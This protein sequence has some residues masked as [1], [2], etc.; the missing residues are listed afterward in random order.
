MI[1][2]DIVKLFKNVKSTGTNQFTALCPCHNDTRNSLSIGVS[3]DGNCTLIHC[4]AGCDTADILREVGL[5]MKDLY[6]SNKPDDVQILKETEYLYHTENGE[7][8][9]KKIRKDYSDGTKTFGFQ[10]PDGN[11]GLNGKS[12]E[13]YNLPSIL[14]SDMVFFVE[15]EKCAD[16]INQSGYTATTLDTGANSRW[17][18]RYTNYLQNKN[19]IAI[20]DND[21]PGFK[22]AKKILD[23]L[24]SARVKILPDISEKEDIFDWIKAGHTMEDVLNLPDFDLISFMSNCSEKSEKG[25]K[26]MGGDLKETQAEK[27]VRLVEGTTDIELFHDHLNRFYAVIPLNGH[28]EIW[29]MDTDVFKLWLQKIYRDNEHKI[30][31]KENLTQA[32]NILCSKAL[33]ENEK[34]ISLNTRIARDGTEHAIWYDL[35]NSDWQTVKITENGWT[36]ENNPPILFKRFKHQKPQ[37]LPYEN[38]DIRKILKYVNVQDYQILFLTWIVCSFIPEIQHPMIILHGEKGAAKTTAS[39]FLKNLIDPSELDTLML[40]KKVDDL[41]INLE[42]HWFLPFDNISSISTETSDTLCQ[43]ITGS[44]IQKRKLYTDA[45]DYIFIF[46]RCMLMNGINNMATRPDLLD[47]SILIELTRI[48]ESDRK[49]FAMMKKNFMNDLPSILGGVLNLLSTAMKI[50]PSVHLDSLPRMADFARWGFAVGEALG[51][52][53]QKFLDEYNE[54]QGIQ[55]MEALNTDLVAVLLV[56]FMEYR[57]EWEGRVSELYQSLKNFALQIGINTNCKEF[58]RQPNGLSRRL[59]ELRSNLQSAGITFES[60]QRSKGTF[61][62]IKN[63]NESPLPPFVSLNHSTVSDKNILFESND[64]SEKNGDDPVVIF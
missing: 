7:L 12:H 54:N 51:G 19:I 47:R 48:S 59:N 61:I 35:T 53:G 55:N 24:P 23:N 16:I 4:F 63:T 43:A 2:T 17:N 10:T 11:Y 41:I 33:F 6:V 18:S 25:Y 44:G 27:L 13:L 8:S 64:S 28:N 62:C 37:L 39:K 22:Y 49:E 31:S 21:M 26:T 56:S 46:Q 40:S 57:Y 38:G 34:E 58:P 36:I 50:Y 32:I 30:I 60:E 29:N 1:T 45:E 15:G 3:D 5:E 42:K 9:Y 14:S 20:P 52:L